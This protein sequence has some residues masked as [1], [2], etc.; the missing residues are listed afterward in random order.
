MGEILLVLYVVIGVMTMLFAESADH[1]SD[2]R[3]FTYVEQFCGDLLIIVTWPAIWLTVW[4]ML[5]KDD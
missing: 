4:L 2:E 3:T 1:D 5:R